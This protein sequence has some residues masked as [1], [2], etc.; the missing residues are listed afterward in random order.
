MFSFNS[1]ANE[2]Y[3]EMKRI[4]SILVVTTL[5]LFGSGCKKF[6]SLDPPNALSGNNFWKTRNDVE[7]FTNGMY[8]LLRK[9]VARLDMKADAGAFNFPFFAF[10]GDLRGGMAKET[11]TGWGRSYIA[12]LSNNNIKALIIPGEYWYG[13]FNMGRFT[14]WDNFYK[15]IAAANIAVDRVD[16]VPDPSLT[17]ADKKQYKA[18]AIF[19]RNM[20]YFLMVRQWGDVA[21]YTD[22][23]HSAPLKRMPMVEVLKNCREDLMSVKE[24]LPWTYKDPVFVAVRGMRGSAL[25]L[26]MHIN[27]WLAGF[28]TGNEKGYYEAV[29]ALGDELYNENAGAYELL[30]LERNGEIFKG[31]SKEGLF[32]VPQ[33]A[34]YGESFGWSYYYDLVYYNR[35]TKDDSHPYISYDTKFMETIYPVGQ[36]DKRIDYWFDASTMYSND[37]TFKMLKFFVNRDPNSVD[38]TSFDA[39]QII[40]RYTDAILLQAEALA[41][42]GNDTKA[43]EKVN[44]V[45]GRAAAA[46]LTSTGGDLKNDIFFERCRELLGEGHYWFDVVRTKRII[47][48]SYK[49]GYHCTVEQ[50]K[51]GAWTWP[52][53]Q[54]ALVNNPGMTLNTYWQ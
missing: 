49:F 5:L 43:Q 54:S 35:L 36:A 17:E 37:K 28:D 15:V 38:G 27:M 20:A 33:N 3:S 53:H 46:P 42:L 18:E 40:F 39:S 47:D 41:N 19:I 22:A 30:P 34:N 26:L 8:E 9:S 32:E 4:V 31:R 2:K 1:N 7:N 29:D 21:Y 24:D 25:A 11:A 45:R 23:Y 50:F 6:L 13:I 44:I 14:Q 16:G 10:S 12:N 51:A 48:P 52:I